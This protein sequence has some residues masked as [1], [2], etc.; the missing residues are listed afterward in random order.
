MFLMSDLRGGAVPGGDKAY[1]VTSVAER[2]LEM[3][4]L[5]SDK[6]ACGRDSPSG[7]PRHQE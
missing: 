5:R 6:P 1:V 4:R 3:K 2:K 7:H